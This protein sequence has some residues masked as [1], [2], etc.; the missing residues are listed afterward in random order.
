[1]SA[2]NQL[3]SEFNYAIRNLKGNLGE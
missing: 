2:I 3:E 1:M